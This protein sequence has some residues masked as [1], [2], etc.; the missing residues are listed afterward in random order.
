VSAI[1]LVPV[2]SYPRTA[3]LGQRCAMTVDLRHDG[4][5][6]WPFGAEEYPLRCLID[7][8]GLF[9]SRA[10]GSDVLL[11]HRFGGTYGPIVFMLDAVR[12]ERQG[13]IRITLVNDAGVP[14]AS[15]DLDETRVTLE[16]H[17]DR[18]VGPRVVT[19]AGPAAGG[20]QRSFVWLQVGGTYALRYSGRFSEAK[21]QSF[22]RDVQSVLARSGPVDAILMTGDFVEFRALDSLGKNA[23]AF[24][25]L[26]SGVP[27]LVGVPIFVV[28]GNHEI[29]RPAFTAEMRHLATL[30]EKQAAVRDAFWADGS[31]PLRLAVE[32]AFAP[33]FH[34]RTRFEYPETVTV[35]DGMIPGDF[36]ASIDTP[37]GRIGIVGL[38]TE[39]LV[40]DRSRTRRDLDPR[41]IVAACHGDPDEW[42]RAHDFRILMTHSPPQH[43]SPRSQ[44]LYS[45]T[46]APPGRFDVHVTGVPNA[47]FPAGYRGPWCLPSTPFAISPKRAQET[48]SGYFIARLEGEG[49]K[50][51]LLAWPRV[52]GSDDRLAAD[53]AF[54]PLDEDGVVRLAMGESVR[55]ELQTAARPASGAAPEMAFAERA[56]RYGDSK[57]GAP[58]TPEKAPKKQPK[59]AA[60]KE[61]GKRGAKKGKR[62]VN[63]KTAKRTA[64]KAAK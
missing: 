3:G 58:K 39:L 1:E 17:D 13:H 30:W 42:A 59:K 47:P 4:W 36:S 16:Y 12:E 21:Q 22:I 61:P 64:K 51:F 34:W 31:H 53:H 54:F 41:Q 14:V 62:P 2:V 24:E 55:Y 29:H 63:P 5:K 25:A 44:D 7:T 6:A 37:R 40:A 11:V 23:N 32:G 38:N 52:F 20:K 28:P 49:T 50:K 57:S 15:F 45:A 8:D 48:A 60:K 27:G 46:I 18:G 19:G 56:S 9:T 35:R 33:F 10:V 26:R 43:F